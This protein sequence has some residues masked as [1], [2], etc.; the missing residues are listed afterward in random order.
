M[1]GCRERKEFASLRGLVIFN[2]KLLCIAIIIFYLMT[3]Y[4][5]VETIIA[6]STPE[7]MVAIQPFF[8]L[9]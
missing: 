4:D 2:G 8:L 5:A 7:K 9:Q 3:K 6:D 1:A